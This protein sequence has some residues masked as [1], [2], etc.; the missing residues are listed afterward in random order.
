MMAAP[1]LG[2]CAMSFPMTS[3]VPGGDDITGSL[4]DV[5]FGQLLDEE[6]RRRERAALATALD[7]QGDGATIHWENPKT[8]HKGSITASGHAYPADNKVCRGF[9]GDLTHKGGQRSMQGTAC[10][11]AAGEWALKTVDAPKKV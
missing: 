6:D 2:G 8:G 10:I 9:T 11:V 1:L 4:A 3:M 5:P 7:P